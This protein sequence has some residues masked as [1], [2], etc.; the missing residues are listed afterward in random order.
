MGRSSRRQIESPDMVGRF[1]LGTPGKSASAAHFLT[2]GGYVDKILIIVDMLNDFIKPD[3]KLYFEKGQTVV[4]PL[5]RLKA[6]FRTAGMPV[7]YDNDA[8]PEDSM[9]FSVWP[10]HCLAG[11]WGARIIEEL[12]AGPGDII[13]HKDSLSLFYHS[14]AENLLRGLGV[15]H[16]YLAGV[17]TEYCVKACALDALALGFSVTVIKDA[18]A[19]VDLKAGDAATALEAMRQAGAFFANTETII[20][21]LG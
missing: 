5:V 9:E 4:E 17:A 18:V 20:T 14:W 12:P 21:D 13:F 2:T 10:P 11:T 3:G 8:H 16:L 15:S 1:R 6:A 7:L 19:G